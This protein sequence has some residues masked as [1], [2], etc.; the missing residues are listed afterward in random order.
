[1]TPNAGKLELTF[2]GY[3][4]LRMATDPDPT[5]DPRG[6]SGYTFALAGEPD[7]DGILHL[8]PGEPGVW[9]RDFGGDSFAPRVG[10]KVTAAVRNGVPVPGLVGAEVSLPGARLVERNGLVVRNDFFA[11]DPVLVRLSQNGAVLLERRDELD[12]ARPGLPIV[13]ADTPMLLRRQPARWVMNS[14]QVAAATGLP[15]PVTDR[16]LID[17]RRARQACL[18]ALL[19]N[20]QDPTSRAALEVR[21]REL[22]ILRRWWDLSQIGPDGPPID[23]R[24]YT[25]A[26]Q[27]AG[28]N[29]G[30]NGAV[31]VNELGGDVSV[32]WPLSFWLGGWDGDALC[33][34]IEGSLT[35]PLSGT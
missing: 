31:S 1:M 34:Y 4:Q 23:R 25:L 29:M 21:I 30:L 3:F 11:L 7:F 13:A 18:A 6:L 28:W 35:V 9:E 22:S 26:L 15:Q 16:A 32:A 27:A 5:D 10:V 19:E 8:Q 14:A 33:A 17:N 20:T 2:G 24:A 12:P